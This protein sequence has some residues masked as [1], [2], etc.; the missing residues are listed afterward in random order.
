MSD[1]A[2]SKLAIAMTWAVIVIAVVSL[3]VGIS[4]YGFSWEVHQRF[5][6]DIFGRLH[7][8]MTFRFILQPALGLV[9]A[10]K[11]GIKDAR[12]GHKAFFWTA[13]W[14]RT[15]ERSR[16]REGMVATSRTA[17]IGFSMDAIYQVKVFDRFY[18][19][20]S[21]MMV[22]LLAVIPYFIFRWII[23]YIARWWLGRK[24][25]ST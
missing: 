18:P 25:V 5:W 22:L 2:P 14:D 11:D 17:L 13:L 21:V 9:A 16:L 15:Q 10:L 6:T 3:V 7:G 8:P 23:E 24:A 19:V 1:S 12:A 4:W 20:E